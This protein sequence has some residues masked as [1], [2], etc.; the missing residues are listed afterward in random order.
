MGIG[1]E[2]ES[3]RWLTKTEK[4]K[5]VILQEAPEI[6]VDRQA[7]KIELSIEIETEEFNEYLHLFNKLWKAPM[8][9]LHFAALVKVKAKPFSLPFIYL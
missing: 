3:M 4:I 2:E 1:I 8:H 7:D 5:E 9:R 6:I